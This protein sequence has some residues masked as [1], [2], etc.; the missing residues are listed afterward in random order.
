[1]SGCAS[2]GDP[3]IADGIEDQDWAYLCEYCE[4]LQE[5]GE[6]INDLSMEDV[7]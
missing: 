5:S 4:E 6:S 3:I 1:M 7:L 2:C